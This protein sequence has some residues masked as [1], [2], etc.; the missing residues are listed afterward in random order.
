MQ[1]DEDRD[2]G[3]KETSGECVGNRLRL[4]LYVYYIYPARSTVVTGQLVNFK[5]M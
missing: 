2:G 5:N 1:D 4:E 3:G